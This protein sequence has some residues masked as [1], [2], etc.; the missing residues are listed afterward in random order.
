MD[1]YYNHA[2]VA[3]TAASGDYGYGTIWPAASHHVTAVGGTSLLPASNTRGWDEIAWSGGGSGCS[4]YETRPSWQHDTGC[5]QRTVADVAAVA[6]PDAGGVAVYDSY[7]YGVGWWLSAAQASPHRSSRAFKRWPALQARTHTRRATHT[8]TAPD[9]S[10]S[11]PVRTHSAVAAPHSFA[12]LGPVTTARPVSEPLT[13][14]PPSSKPACDW[15]PTTPATSVVP[16]CRARR[17]PS[18][19]ASPPT[20]AA[21]AAEGRSCHVRPLLSPARVI[22]PLTRVPSVFFAHF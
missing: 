4:P 20:S 2:G 14:S 12:R 1:H 16:P 13:A 5:T 17:A 8:Q 11:C 7:F 22:S 10:T 21:L 15:L 6:D 3:V 9:Y 18:R 19:R